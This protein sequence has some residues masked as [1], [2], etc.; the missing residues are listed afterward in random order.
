MLTMNTSRPPREAIRFRP[1]TPDD[2][3]FLRR[4]YG[5]TREE[6]MQRVPWTDEQKTA[7]VDMQFAAQKE[8]YETFYPDCEFLVIELEGERIGR[9]YIDRGEI[10]I[11][12]IDIALLPEYRGRGLGGMLLEEI[13]AEGR[14]TGKNV[15]IYVEHYNPARHLYERLGFRH[16]DS[17]GIYHKMQWRADAT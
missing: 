4:V 10:D 13:L 16:V 17:N 12:I 7:F 2:I 3:P 9:L 5:T 14:A 1:I 15:Q 8:H 6:E 11:E